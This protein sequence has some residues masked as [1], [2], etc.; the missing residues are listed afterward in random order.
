LASFQAVSSL[1]FSMS[2]S[3]RSA[4]WRRMLFTCRGQRNG[5]DERFS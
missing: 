5:G 4:T 2:M 3:R 1:S